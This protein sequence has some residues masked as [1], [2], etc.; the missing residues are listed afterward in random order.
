MFPFKQLSLSEKRN[1]KGQ[2]RSIDE[3]QEVIKL[4]DVLVDVNDLQN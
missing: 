4:K 1:K 2:K 3:D